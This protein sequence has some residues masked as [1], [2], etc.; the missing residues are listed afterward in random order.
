MLLARGIHV[1]AIDGSGLTPLH[2]AA[3]NGDADIVNV[4]R[5]KGADPRTKSTSGHTPL[6]L[7]RLTSNSQRGN[8]PFMYVIFHC[9]LEYIMG[10]SSSSPEVEDFD[11]THRISEGERSMTTFY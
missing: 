4:F 9:R 1:N 10:N 6:V 7:S 8:S 5:T 3:M 11:I 2:V